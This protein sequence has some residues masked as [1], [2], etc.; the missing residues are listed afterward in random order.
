MKSEAEESASILES[1]VKTKV[2]NMYRAS[3]KPGERKTRS[4]T[5]HIT[6]WNALKRFRILE[7]HNGPLKD[8]G[9]SATPIKH[10]KKGNKWE[11]TA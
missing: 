11:S 9:Y 6:A 8:L 10:A 1:L 5:N 2:A 7:E 4:L 3:G